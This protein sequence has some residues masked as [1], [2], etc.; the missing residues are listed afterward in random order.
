MQNSSLQNFVSDLVL[1]ES[2]TQDY[3]ECLHIIRAGLGNF[4]T[5]GDAL[6]RV[7]DRRLYRAVAPTF[8]EF[9]RTV[10]G[11]T[12]QYGNSL[13]ASSSIVKSLEACGEFGGR[14]P[15]NEAHVRPLR[16]LPEERCAPVWREVLA[17]AA[18]KPVTAKLVASVAR[19][20]LSQDAADM[21]TRPEE[22]RER[23]Q[24][25]LEK[26]RKT[27]ELANKE[28]YARALNLLTEVEALL[29][30]EPPR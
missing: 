7:R 9:C 15:Q 22:E 12:P 1:D 21:E 29:D 13:I 20:H 4:L 6:A 10:L 28:S 14:L 18:Q 25:Q 2:E 11:L 19:K 23:I 5:V 17:A 27:M 3:A 24:K 26:L 8:E 30:S 16:A